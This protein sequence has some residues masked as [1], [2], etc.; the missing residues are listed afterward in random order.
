MTATITPAPAETVE[1]L[2]GR[3]FMEGVGAFHL[4]TV[5]LGVKLGFFTT[6]SEKDPITAAE[7]AN[8]T[9]LDPWYVR[10]VTQAEVTAGL[11][12]ADDDELTRG[13]LRRSTRRPR[14][15]RPGD[16]PGVPRRSSPRSRRSRGHTCRTCSTH[17]A[18]APALPPPPTARTR[19][20]AQSA[21]NRPAFVN[22]LVAEW[23]PA[24]PRPARAPPRHLEAGPRR[25][26][27]M[28]PGL[29]GDRA[30]QGIPAHPRRRVRLRR[31]V[32]LTGAAQRHRQRRRRP[33]H[34]PGGRRRSRRVRRPWSYDAILFFGVH[35]RHGPPGRRP[36]RRPSVSGFRRHGDRDR[37]SGSRSR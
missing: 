31:G 11:V 10:R 35:P 33:R 9:G 30:G 16:Q 8:A 19:S 1:E 15:A 25:R 13:T 34:L 7:L 22:Q 3:L 20:E 37:A 36:G 12:I 27:R 5:Y 2:V 6:L 23:L 28:R 4:S 21:L 32:G 24:T 14:D 26:R 29:G 18:P 17:S